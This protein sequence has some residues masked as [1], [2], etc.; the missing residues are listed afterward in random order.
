ML[1]KAHQ[2]LTRKRKPLLL[3]PA[4]CTSLLFIKAALNRPF[5]NSLFP[6]VSY[7]R[8]PLSRHLQPRSTALVDGSSSREAVSVGAAASPAPVTDSPSAV[9]L[10]GPDQDPGR[11]VL[12]RPHLHG[13]PLRG[14]R[15]MQGEGRAPGVTPSHSHSWWGS[16]LHTLVSCRV[17]GSPPIDSGHPLLPF[18]GWGGHTGACRRPSLAGAA[19]TGSVAL[20]GLE[21]SWFALVPA[22]APSAAVLGPA[23]ASRP[24]PPSWSPQLP[25]VPTG[26]SWGLPGCVPSPCHAEL[27][28]HHY[29]DTGRCAPQGRCEPQHGS[30]VLGPQ[31]Q[32]ESL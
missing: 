19:G 6:G 11:P 25:T 32:A 23:Q 17:T 16:V 13:L 21:C 2:A 8:P 14:E 12:A 15:A 7:V 10:A 4:V 24:A 5:P 9:F 22:P 30:T 18:S 26:A 28:L 31:A 29:L 20:H 27:W 3:T 1:G